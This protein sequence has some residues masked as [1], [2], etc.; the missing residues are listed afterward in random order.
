MTLKELADKVG[1]TEATIQKYEAGNIKKIDIEMLKKLADA[2]D[3][4]PES[5]TEWGDG[6]YEKYREEKQGS[7]DAKLV[8]AYNQ[9]TLGHKKAVRNLIDNLL[10][11]QEIYNSDK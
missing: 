10:K 2:L 3:V 5:L 11:C 8:K 7:Q 1:L 9:L 6:E 4:I